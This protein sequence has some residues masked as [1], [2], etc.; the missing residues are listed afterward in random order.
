MNTYEWICKA[1]DTPN[2]LVHDPDDEK[3]IAL[4]CLKCGS[5][6]LFEPKTKTIL[7]YEKGEPFPTG[8]TAVCSTGVSAVFSTD[9]PPPHM[10]TLDDR[11]Y[12]D[13]EMAYIKKA[14]R[15]TL[16]KKKGFLPSIL[17]RGK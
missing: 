3:Q 10:V 6:G 11:A 13:R 9:T 8:R 16:P 12:H 17:R 5:P 1:C 4:S 2:A 15:K 14:Y 7:H